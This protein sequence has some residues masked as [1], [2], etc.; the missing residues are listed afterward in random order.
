MNA[1]D[2]I[3]A[4]EVVDGHDNVDRV[5]SGFRVEKLV[6]VE[7]MHFAIYLK[8]KFQP[9]NESPEADDHDRCA[10]AAILTSLP[11]GA[12]RCERW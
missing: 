2:P 8:L 11:T 12:R 5:K 7:A 1:Q 3:K 6:R 10:S 9:V 4:E